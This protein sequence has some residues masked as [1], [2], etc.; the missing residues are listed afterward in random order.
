MMNYSR[1]LVK[2]CMDS[3]VIYPN[4]ILRKVSRRVNEVNLELESQVETLVKILKSFGGT[5]AGLAANQ[6]GID[7]RF[8]AL[9]DSK[10]KIQV[11]FNHQIT[12]YLGEKTYPVM[13]YDNGEKE[14]FLEGCLSFPNLFGEVKRYLKIEAEWQ[15]LDKGKLVD[16]KGIFDGFEA[17]VFQHEGEHLDGVLFVDHILEEGGKLYE[18]DEKGNKKKLVDVKTVIGNKI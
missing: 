6:I 5:A 11:Y 8:F 12:K 13:V 9:K 18:I 17:I 7:Q 3:L 14:N 1:Y 10:G 15:E 2:Y 4:P 16:K